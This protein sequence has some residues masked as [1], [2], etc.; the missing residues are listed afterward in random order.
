MRDS[1]PGRVV[2]PGSAGVPPASFFLDGFFTLMH[3]IFSGNGWL[4][5][6]EIR[7]P[8]PDH[9]PTR[10]PVLE[11]LVLFILCILCIHVHKN[12]EPFA[13]FYRHMRQEGP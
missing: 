5:I 13:K 8:A 3:R 10:L 4:G 11:R 7:K 2:P 6:L 9:R 1:L 12:Q